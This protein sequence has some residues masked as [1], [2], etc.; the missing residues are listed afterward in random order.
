MFDSKTGM[1]VNCCE[2][3]KCV[4]TIVALLIIGKLDQFPT[5]SKRRYP[6]GAYRNPNNLRVIDDHHLVDMTGLARRYDKSDWV[7]ILDQAREK[8]REKE[9]EERLD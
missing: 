4:R 5:F 2:C 7:E 6:L 3:E 1:P 8:R 9:S